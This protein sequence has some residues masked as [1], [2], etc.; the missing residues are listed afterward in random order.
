MFSTDG[1]LVD[2]DSKDFMAQP[3]WDFEVVGRQFFWAPNYPYLTAKVSD[4]VSR[5]IIEQISNM[6]ESQWLFNRDGIV[7]VS[8]L[9]IEIKASLSSPYA[10]RNAVEFIYG[11]QADGDVVFSKNA[12]N[13]QNDLDDSELAE[14]EQGSL[15]T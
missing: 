4:E 14:L 6:I 10:V 1:Y 2:Q 15:L 9:D 3:A 8:G 11:S 5:H 12:P 7:L 13:F